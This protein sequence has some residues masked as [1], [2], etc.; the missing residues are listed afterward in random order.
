MSTFQLND[1][2]RSKA[3]YSGKQ[4]DCAVRAIAIATGK[5]YK[6]V[7]DALEFKAKVNGIA[8]ATSKKYLLSLGWKWIP[9]MAIGRE[10]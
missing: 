7:Y 9:T 1:G 6:E 3:G 8:K 10:G 4:S 2:G 5:P